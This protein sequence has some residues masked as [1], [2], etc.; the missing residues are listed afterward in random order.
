MTF[1]RFFFV[2]C[3]LADCYQAISSRSVQQLVFC[4]SAPPEQ[5]SRSFSQ[6][7]N[8]VALQILLK[9][10]TGCATQMQPLQD[11][12]KVYDHDLNKSLPFEYWTTESTV[13][14]TL[15]SLGLMLAEMQKI[16]LKPVSKNFS[17]TY[18][19]IVSALAA[20]CLPATQTGVT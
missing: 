13:V 7:G 12:S 1:K 20:L 19:F 9:S 5:W 16:R 8:C 14:L 18:L 4:V 3:F 10:N 11:P 17:K 2:A 6:M 15:D